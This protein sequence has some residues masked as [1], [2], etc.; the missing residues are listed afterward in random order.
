M[1]AAAGQATFNPLCL[2]P[3]L[4]SW[5]GLGSMG[6]LVAQQITAHE[7]ALFY[8]GLKAHGRDFR[9]IQRYQLPHRTRS[10]LVGWY[11]DAWKQKATPHAAQYYAE[12]GQE[13]L[14]EKEVRKYLCV[15]RGGWG[16][17]RQANQRA[18]TMRE[19]HFP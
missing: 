9:A 8:R 14:M 6:L 5:L 12:K 7:D 4:A 10:E 11:Y 2:C 18:I 17:V 1:L 13:K 15:P 16:G 3:P 19:G